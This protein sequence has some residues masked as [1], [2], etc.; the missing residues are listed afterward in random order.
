MGKVNMGKTEVQGTGYDYKLKFPLDRSI[1]QLGNGMSKLVIPW[2]PINYLGVRHT[3]TGDLTFEHGYV[4][5]KTLDTITQSTQHMY[6]PQ[7]IHWVVQVAIIPIFRYSAASVNCDSKE[8]VT[9]ENL[10][11]RAFKKKWRVKASLPDVTFCAGP[12]PG[13]ANTKG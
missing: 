5:K 10:W 12:E 6:H 8:I 4:R 9:L 7:H 3:I 2:D 11:M 13:L 1:F